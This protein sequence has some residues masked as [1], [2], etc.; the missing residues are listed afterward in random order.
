MGFPINPPAVFSSLFSLLSEESQILLHA[1]FYYQT[2]QQPKQFEFRVRI[3]LSIIMDFGMQDPYGA[4]D[5]YEDPYGGGG[6]LLEGG[7]MEAMDP[8]GRGGI[9]GGH[10]GGGAYDPY[11]RRGMQDLGSLG[12]AGRARGL[13]ALIGRGGSHSGG[14]YIAQGSQL[15][16]FYEHIAENLAQNRDN[17]PQ[18]PGKGRLLANRLGGHGRLSERLLRRGFGEEGF[19]GSMGGFGGRSARGRDNFGG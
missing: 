12:L 5:G 4:A 15:R 9:G 3:T 16:A 6:R 2:L 11:E 8:F 18:G 17:P 14:H 13:S 19:G 7:G 1:K 10:G